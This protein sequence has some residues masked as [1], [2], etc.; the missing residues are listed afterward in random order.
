MYERIRITGILC[1]CSDLHV[2]SGDVG[3]IT[4]RVKDAEEGSYRR[5]TLDHE[6]KPFIPASTLR[7]WL[8]A[9]ARSIGSAGNQ[10]LK[11][12][13]VNGFGYSN[14]IGRK[15]GRIR[16]QDATLRSTVSSSA[17]PKSWDA[18]SVTHLHHGIALDSR[19]GVVEDHKLF[20]YEVIPTGSQFTFCIEMDR[21][22]TEE[23]PLLLGLLAGW[24][25]SQ[26]A[27]IGGDSGT[28]QGRLQWELE[29]V[30][31]LTADSIQAWLAGEQDSG[32]QKMTSIPAASILSAYTLKLRFGLD[33]LGGL[34]VNDPDWVQEKQHDD[35]H[36]PK[37]VYSRLLDGK[38]RV[39][40]RTLR[41]LIRARAQRILATLLHQQGMAAEVAS[42]QAKTLLEPFFGG[43]QKAACLFL[44]DALPV[45]QHTPSLRPSI[46]VDRFVGGVKGGSK[47]A[48]DGALWAA[49]VVEQVEWQGD[50]QLDISRLPKDDWW[51]GLLLFVVRDAL[52]GDL[53]IGS[54]KSKGL[55][56]FKLK[57]YLPD[58][59]TMTNWQTVLAYLK[60]NGH[61]ASAW[62]QSL[63]DYL[64]EHT[65]KKEKAA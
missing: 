39:P 47:G 28:G 24:D 48:D 46:A 12:F 37:Q 7:G 15:A 42:Q 50:A 22:E 9:Y 4:S 44:S 29:K 55:G 1:L 41:G 11:I 10:Q 52:E 14:D 25:G 51:K 58:E 54:G 3:D 21:C 5:V 20:H 27:A 26:T 60:T 49:E 61:D 59:S 19:T 43:E 36:S 56:Q 18:Q 32:W 38:A 6:G 33:T 65:L 40:G 53:A 8:R 17:Y 16:V 35:D 2:G 62:V 57:L 23:F 64:R 63:H 45:K 13:E 30:E 31:T 34:L